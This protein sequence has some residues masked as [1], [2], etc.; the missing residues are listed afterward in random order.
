MK[1]KSMKQVPRE[2]TILVVFILLGI[3]AA[4]V[5]LAGVVKVLER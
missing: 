1:C 5:A 4:G 3:A 2:A